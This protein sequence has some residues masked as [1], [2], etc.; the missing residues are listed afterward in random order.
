MSTEPRYIS[1]VAATRPANTTAYTALDVIGGTSAALSIFEFA[2]I[3]PNGGGPIVLL[4][5][6]L[7]WDASALPSGASQTRLHL[8]NASPTGIAD[9]AAFNLIAGDRDKYLG[10]INLGT[11]VDIG[12]TLY[13]ADDYLRKSIVATSSSIFGVAQTVA[14]FTPT[15]GAVLNWTLQ[16]V[17]A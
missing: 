14:D 1:T 2:N 15:S 7:R 3:A 17:K 5:A 8:F 9:N 11:P 6:S 10:V 12:D 13:V 16:A 4:S